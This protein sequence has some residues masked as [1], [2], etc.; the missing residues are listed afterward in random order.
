MVLLKSDDQ[1]GAEIMTYLLM[2]VILA[3]YFVCFK[4]NKRPHNTWFFLPPVVAGLG[5]I[6]GANYLQLIPSFFF[7]IIALA[8]MIYSIMQSKNYQRN[9]CYR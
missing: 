3:S 1:A 4:M 9:G 7:V 2:F 5:W 8:P 6:F